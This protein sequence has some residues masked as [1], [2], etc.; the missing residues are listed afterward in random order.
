MNLPE[1]AVYAIRYAHKK[2]RSRDDNFIAPPGLPDAHDS[3][4]PIDYFIWA[5]VGN[6]HTVVV[7]TGFDHAEAAQRGRELTRLPREGL[8]LLDIDSHAVEDVIITHLHYDHAGTLSDFPNAKFH[9]QDLE[10]QYATGRY[11][12]YEAFR[13]AYT[14]GHVVELVRKLYEGRVV[15]HNGD[16]DLWPG[17][18]VHHIGGHT[19][20][21][22]AV[23]VHTQRG[24]LVL[25]SDASH[26]YKNMETQTPFPI[27]YNVADMLEGHAKLYR[28]ADSRQQVIPGHDPLV[29]QR[30][31]A[32]S[33]ELQGIVV[34]LDLAPLE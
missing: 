22:Q 31:L 34:Q 8:A 17:L 29:M 26:F 28:L 14:A 18:S 16:E 2:E 30:Y 11:M 10:M 21:I 5:I 15:F 20:G 9:I 23:R 27:V 19:M 3:P 4:I 12:Q 33:K 32:P 25:A 13:Y 1:Y 7:D 24:W 6:G